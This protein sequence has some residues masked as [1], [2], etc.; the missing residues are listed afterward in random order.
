MGIYQLYEYFLPIPPGNG[1]GTVSLDLEEGGASAGTYD[2]FIDTFARFNFFDTESE[3]DAETG[4]S[5]SDTADFLDTFQLASVDAT[6]GATLIG[7]DGTNFTALSSAPE[8]NSMGLAASAL[9]I[10]VVPVQ[11]R[12]AVHRTRRCPE[13]PG[14]NGTILPVERR[15]G[16]PECER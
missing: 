15:K 10:F 14:I 7:A 1:T 16:T 13:V 9:M 8:P 11:R 6:N 5:V 12:R 3:I 2:L 4:E